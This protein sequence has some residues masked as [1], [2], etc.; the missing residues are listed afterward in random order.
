[1]L[2]PRLIAVLLLK[3][4][5]IVRSREFSFHQSLGDPIGQVERFSSWKADEIIYLDISREGGHDYRDRLSMIGSTTSKK[6]IPVTFRDSFVDVVRCI[7]AKC[8]VPLTIGGKIRTLDDMRI[9]LKNG[10]DKVSINTKA[11]SDPSFITR[12]AK[13]FGSQCIIVSVD[14]KYDP[15]TKKHEV[16]TDFGKKPTGLDPV[17]WCRE[18]EERG[19]GEILLNSIDRDG[20]GKGYDLVLIRKVVNSVS[21]PVI[22]LGGVGRFEHFVEGLRDAQATAVAAANIFNFTEQSIINAKKYMK[23]SGIDMRV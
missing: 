8:T 21:I 3:N 11:I 22:A 10:A 16:Y 12:A 6:D 19:A 1:M 17:L 4:G 18:V 13:L 23:E 9:C 14:A 15:I 2:K 5:I 7:S 20:T